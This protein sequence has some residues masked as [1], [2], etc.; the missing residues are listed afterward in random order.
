MAEPDWHLS[1]RDTSIPAAAIGGIGTAAAWLVVVLTDR[2]AGFVG[3]VWMAAGLVLY[4]A[5]RK[6]K[7][8]S[9]NKQSRA[10]V[11]RLGATDAHDEILVPLTGSRVTDEMMVLACQLATEKRSSVDGLYVIEVPLNL[12]LDARL[13]EERRKADRVLAAAALV[14]DSFKVWF[15]P[16]VSPPAAGKAIVEE[17]SA[18][19]SR[20]HPRG[21]PEAPH[22]ATSF[23]ADVDYVLDHAPCEVLLNLVPRGYPTGLRRA[24]RQSAART[25]TVGSRDKRS[26]LESAH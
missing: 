8:Y 24:G 3:L 9:L 22:W 12:P 17:A 5:Y 13:S 2:G 15:T 1:V 26:A 11:H 19:R 23:R 20:C 14:A 4:V 21:H 6:V 7:G 10:A 25:T 18:R 16:H